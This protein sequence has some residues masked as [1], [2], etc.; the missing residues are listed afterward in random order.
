MSAFW[1]SL[2][3]V[4]LWGLAILAVPV[5]LATFGL[6]IFWTVEAAGGGGRSWDRA[7]FAFA[8]TVLCV[9]YTLVLRVHSSRVLIRTGAFPALCRGDHTPTTEAELLR[10]VD[11]IYRETGKLPTIVGSGWGFFIRHHGARGRRIFMHRFKGRQQVDSVRWRSGTTIAQAAATILEEDAMTFPSHPTMDYISLG[12]WFA[13]GNHGNGGDLNSGS[14]KCLRNARVLNMKTR[15]VETLEYPELRR[16]F[17]GVGGTDGASYLVIDVEFKNLIANDDVQKR[18]IIIDSP[19]AAANWLKPGAYLRVCFQGAAR[20][21][22]IGARWEEVY[23][24]ATHRD[25]HCCSR[26][27]LFL[28][29]DIFSVFGGWHESM[30]AYNGITTRYEANRW[31]PSV[32]P[33][34]TVSVLLS[35]IRN[36]EVIFL[37]GEP[38][39]G[40]T[41]YELITEMIKLHR[42]HGGRSEFRHGSPS[43]NTPVFMDC[44]MARGHEDVFRMLYETFDVQEAALHPGKFTALSIDPIGRVP[45][46]KVYGM[47]R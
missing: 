21:Y 39:N 13:Y 25:P 46:S 44:A 34:E 38:L 36:F 32:Y 33:I 18:G 15:Q 26:L 31:M 10:A 1:Y 3:F 17:D 45:L 16:R 35:G 9:V 7:V 43:T 24:Q 20:N 47:S 19:Q 14:S 42:I 41:L 37:M 22:A 8:F 28:Q 29:M 23:E 5:S 4:T 30:S 11:E 40:N 27:C 6:G 2:Y 12:A